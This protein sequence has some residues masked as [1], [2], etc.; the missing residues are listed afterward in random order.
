M[1]KTVA[2]HEQTPPAPFYLTT[3]ECLQG[4]PRDQYVYKGYQL[5]CEMVYREN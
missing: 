1:L 4:G 2:K 3:S 5:L